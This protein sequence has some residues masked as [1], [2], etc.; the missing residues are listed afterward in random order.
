[1]VRNFSVAR[2]QRE[3]IDIT[4]RPLHDPQEVQRRAADDRDGIP[5]PLRGE[6]V[7]DHS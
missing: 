3:D 2:R 5:Q 4:G 7:T 6:K 1:M